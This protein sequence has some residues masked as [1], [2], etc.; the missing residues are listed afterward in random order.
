MAASPEISIYPSY[1]LEFPFKLK[2]QESIEI[3]IIYTS[4][5]VG[6]FETVMYIVVDEWTY[7]TT[8]NAMVRPNQF[9]LEPIYFTDVLIN[10]EIQLPLN[11][12]NPLLSTYLVVEELYS[13]ES[14][15]QL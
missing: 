11:F 5:T 3:K 9:D 13:T 2:S 12:T 10:E 15:L 7:V 14:F 8:I 4:E 1:G 6:L